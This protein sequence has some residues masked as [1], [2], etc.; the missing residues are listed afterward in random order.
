MKW[1][2]EKQ[3][4]PPRVGEKRYS[5]KFAIIP[6]KCS[7]GW[8]VW[9]ERY[10]IVEKYIEQYVDWGVVQRSWETIQKLAIKSN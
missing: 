10:T 6:V 8:W 3:N 2:F 4:P 7:S 9:L 1:T 5:E